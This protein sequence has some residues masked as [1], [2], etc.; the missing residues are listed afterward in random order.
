V[1]DAG[2]QWTVF[3]QDS[4]ILAAGLKANLDALKDF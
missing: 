1:T 3:G 2:V 4:R